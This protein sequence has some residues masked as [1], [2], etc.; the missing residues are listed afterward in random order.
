MLQDYGRARV[1]VSQLTG[2]FQCNAARERIRVE[3]LF[4]HFFF[5]PEMYSIGSLEQ[6]NT[7]IKSSRQDKEF[8]VSG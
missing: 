2:G 7:Q 4:F 8:L 3:S 6:N 1:D 5:S